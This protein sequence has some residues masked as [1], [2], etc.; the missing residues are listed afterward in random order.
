MKYGLSTEKADC[1]EKSISESTTEVPSEETVAAAERTIENESPNVIAIS[2]ENETIEANTPLATEEQVDL[3]QVVEKPQ[4]EEP[5][6]SAMSASLNRLIHSSVPVLIIEEIVNDDGKDRADKMKCV[7]NMDV[8]AS[9]EEEMSEVDMTSSRNTPNDVDMTNMAL[10]TANDVDMP[11]MADDLDTFSQTD[12][13]FENAPI[14][15]LSRYSWGVNEQKYLRGCVFSPD[16]TC[17][18][19][20]VNKDG[21]H[22]V[23][24]PLSLYEN[25][26]V[27]ASRPVDI[28]SSAVHVPE[29]GTV[30]DYCWY[31]FMN[32]SSPETCCFISTRQHEPLQLYDAFD[33]KLRCTYRGYDVVDE[34]DHALSVCFSTDGSQIIAGYKKAL[35]I[36]RTDVP[37]RDYMNYTL[38]SA[39]VCL[40]VNSS[41]T[42]TIAIGSWNCFITFHDVRSP[43]L[44][45]TEK[46]VKHTGGVTLLK[47]SSDGQRL[48][49]GARKDK[50]LLV[51][52]TRNLSAPLLCFKR[53]AE[54]NQR[55]YFDLSR[56]GRWL[57]SGDTT[58]ILHAYDLKYGTERG[59]FPDY[60]YPLHRDCCNGVSLHPTR[61]IFATS[62]G[63]HHF[64]GFDDDIPL[65]PP[66]VQENSLIFWWCGKT[67]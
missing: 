8:S 63:K 51:W 62:S 60:Q 13:N 37:G 9:H 11:N 47:F 43:Q 49:T 6:T 26:S 65:E 16:G 28:L 55:I 31:P 7:E 30:Y 56:S 53:N 48:V 42:N 44:A 40:A 3:N 20:N 5:E 27:S 17:I 46:L 19:T 41:D 29:G 10:N 21:F 32:S 25:E 22:V 36:F 50:K 12:Y 24:L 15:E 23:E 64:I 35:K 54:T 14:I 39:A 66:D 4:F 2:K 18:L 45:M 61:P 33:G 58:G 67:A 59:K 38:K 34:V 52:D 57:V 1:E